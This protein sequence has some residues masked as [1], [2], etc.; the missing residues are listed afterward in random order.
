MAQATQA[1]AYAER[2]YGFTPYVPA[3]NFI[4]G[5]FC[6]SVTGRFLDVENPRH[7]KV[8]GKVVRRTT[9]ECDSGASLIRSLRMSAMAQIAAV[10][11]RVP[12]EAKPTDPIVP[13]GST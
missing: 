12:C 7:G 11:S 1:P 2:S 6:D 4:G 8:M 9:L 3:Q 13:P 10:G 5:S